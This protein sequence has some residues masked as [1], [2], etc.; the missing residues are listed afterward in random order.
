MNL[1]YHKGTQDAK[2][3]T[4]VELNTLLFVYFFFGWITRARLSC[5]KLVEQLMKT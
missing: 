4:T 3:C 5:L 2:V 1:S